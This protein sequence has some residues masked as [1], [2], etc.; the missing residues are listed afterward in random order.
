MNSAG[1]KMSTAALHKEFQQIG[2]SGKRIQRRLGPADLF[3]RRG[4][5]AQP[6]PRPGGAAHHPGGPGQGDTPVQRPRPAADRARRGHQPQRRHHTC[7]G[8]GGGGHHR[9]EPHRGDK[10]GG[11]VR[12]GGAGSDQRPLVRRRPKTGPVLSPRSRQPGGVHPGGQRGRKLRRP[13]RAS[14]T[15]SPETT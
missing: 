4:P 7:P 2:R 5:A 1:G 3:L 13:Q 8:G 12:G 10:P 11:P 15:G 14:S 9:P 6:A